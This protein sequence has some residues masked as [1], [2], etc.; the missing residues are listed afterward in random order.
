MRVSIRVKSLLHQTPS[1]AHARKLVH[2]TMR[3]RTYFKS[4]IQTHTHTHTATSSRV[5]CTK[6]CFCFSGRVVQKTSRRTIKRKR[7]TQ[8]LKHSLSI[9]C[10][11][12]IKARRTYIKITCESRQIRKYH[13]RIKSAKS[14]K[15]SEIKRKRYL[16]IVACTF[17]N[18]NTRFSIS[19]SLFLD[20][21]F[22]CI[23]KGKMMTKLDTTVSIIKWK[24]WSGKKNVLIWHKL[25]KH[26]NRF[27]RL[28][29]NNAVIIIERWTLIEWNG[30]QS[31]SASALFFYQFL[32]ILIRQLWK[33]FSSFSS[34]HWVELFFLL[35]W[36]RQSRIYAMAF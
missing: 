9:T 30:M 28:R 27:I 14:W 23:F 18:W 22:Y 19:L 34:S 8:L 35:S 29:Y 2:K 11:E 21:S 33:H 24:L 32:C 16:S 15:Q 7:A 1:R 5:W 6:W 12:Y 17:M 4:L 3:V 25:Q 20:S 10:W 26:S 31:T 36:D 13:F